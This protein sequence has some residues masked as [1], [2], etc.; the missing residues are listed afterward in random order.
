MPPVDDALRSGTL[1]LPVRPEAGMASAVQPEWGDTVSA[2]VLI[3]LSTC[4][5]VAYL[6]SVLHILPHVVKCLFRAK[7]NRDIEASMRLASDRDITAVVCILPFCLVVSRA[8]LY[9]PRF[10]Q[11]L[12]TDASL[13]ATVGIFICYLIFRAAMK[14]GFRPRRNR[15]EAYDDASRAAYNFFITATALL[16]IL[17]PLQI[18]AGAEAVSLQKTGRLVL[19]VLYGILLIREWQI[20]QSDC[21]FFTAFLYLCALELIPTAAMVASALIF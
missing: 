7:A 14:W 10:F 18:L 4:L 12:S 1:L 6:R 20:L 9:A 8:G 19:A 17:C 21:S 2:A 16:C 5:V 13:L 15:A 3:L 11:G